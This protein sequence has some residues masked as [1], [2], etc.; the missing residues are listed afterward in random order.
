MKARAIVFPGV[1]KAEL[2]DLELPSPGAPDLAV[3]VLASGVSV[4]TE[5][6]ALSGKRPEMRF[7]LVTGYMGIGRVTGVGAEAAKRGYREGQAVNFG[8]SRLPEP[9]AGGSWMGTALSHAVVDG[10]TGVDWV[11]GGFNLHRCER[12]PEGLDPVE[13]ALTP[14]CAVALRGIE[15]ARI[16]LGGTVL[17]SGL[18]VIGQFA[19]QVCR[20][21]G[22]RVTATDPVARRLELAGELGAEWIIN[23]RTED[24][25]SRASAIAPNGFDVIIDT[26]SDPK[27]VNSIIGLLRMHGQF[28]FQG[29]YPPPSPL[30]LNAFHGR[31]PTCY[32]P[33]AHTGRSVA[34]AMQWAREGKLNIRRLI[35]HVA[36]P[37]DAPKIY[38]M[39]LAGSSDFLGIVFDWRSR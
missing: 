21:M 22:A 33:C 27:V 18:G 32:M 15:M 11:P 1:G 2:R 20:L 26:S 35:T 28:I 7:P 4:G 24:M 17:V 23:P 25:A 14:L 12:V 39:I 10:C 9:Y 16:P 37:S 34:V 30:D 38:D 13:A 3:E 5:R 8:V 36:R 29:W 19:V 31:L 6:W